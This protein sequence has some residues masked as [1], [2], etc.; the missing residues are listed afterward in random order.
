MAEND[1]GEVKA[2]SVYGVNWFWLD[3]GKLVAQA[4]M[5]DDLERQ[6]EFIEAK[7]AVE[8]EP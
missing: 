2:I 5:S 7:I 4:D 6:V 8:M 3:T 1:S